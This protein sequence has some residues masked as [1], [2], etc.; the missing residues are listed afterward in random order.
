M[1]PPTYR[2]GKEPLES[3]GERPGRYP[4]R[5]GPCREEETRIKSPPLPSLCRQSNTNWPIIQIAVQSLYIPSPGVRI[6]QI[7]SQFL[8]ND[9]SLLLPF[10]ANTSSTAVAP[11]LRNFVNTVLFAI[12]MCY[13]NLNAYVYILVANSYVS[14]FR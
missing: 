10:P 7:H 4:G 3:T 14:V 12:L 2:S 1:S 8:R 6:Y 11:K 9:A 13:N 5:Y